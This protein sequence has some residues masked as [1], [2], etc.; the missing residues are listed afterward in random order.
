MK[1]LGFP[2][3]FEVLDDSGGDGANGFPTKPMLSDYWQ[4]LG[5]ALGREVGVLA[6]LL[7]FMISSSG[8]G[9]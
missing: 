8:R 1:A 2:A 5:I 4:S 9:E 6:G 3:K 7:R